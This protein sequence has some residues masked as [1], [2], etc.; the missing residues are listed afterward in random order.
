MKAL[1]IIA[2]CMLV[3]AIACQLNSLRHAGHSAMG[4][5]KAASVGEAESVA[6]RQE[7]DADARR[8]DRY[9][10]AGIVLAALGVVLWVG[11]WTAGK[12]VNKRLTPVWLVVLLIAYAALFVMR[13]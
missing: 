9:A 12:R 8:C 1:Y 10:L 3:A 5:A 4:L 11:C 7:A 6:A 2:Y 13:V